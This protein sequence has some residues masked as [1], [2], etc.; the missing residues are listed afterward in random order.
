MQLFTHDF[1]AISS[2]RNYSYTVTAAHA[3]KRTAWNPAFG[4]MATW[5][6]IG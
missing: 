4:E 5:S 3:T 2:A 1:A 6:P